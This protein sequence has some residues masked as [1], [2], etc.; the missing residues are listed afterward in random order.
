MIKYSVALLF[1]LLFFGSCFAR[2][3][4]SGELRQHVD[5]ALPE[6]HK[7]VVETLRVQKITIE[8]N[9]I[10]EMTAL[11]VGSYA[12]GSKVTIHCELLTLKASTIT[13]QIGLF[14]DKLKSN[15]LMQEIGS[16][17]K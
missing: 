17:L 11:V 16:R 14:G 6:L 3:G 9:K 13:I 10:D 15:A 12:D 5:A 4:V 1:L 2:G 7:A 8:E